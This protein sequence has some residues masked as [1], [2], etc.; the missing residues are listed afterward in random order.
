MPSLTVAVSGSAAWT[1]GAAPSVPGSSRA[2]GSAS[3]AGALPP[4]PPPPAFEASPTTASTAPT[5]TVSSSCTR[6]SS[7]VP[8]AGE[9]I[10]VSTL[11][12]E[13]SSSG[14]SASTWSPTCLS[15]RLT[16]PSLTLSPRAGSVT[17]VPPPPLAPWVLSAVGAGVSS[18][19]VPP[20]S[21]G[22]SGSKVGADDCSGSTS[23]AGSDSAGASGSAGASASAAA[24]PPPASPPPP[25]SASLGSPIT[26][27]TA[28]TSTVS[29]SA[30]LISSSTP[31]VG[32]GISVSTLSVET[33]SSG[34][35]AST[36]SPTCLSHR[37]TV[38][39]VTLSPRAGRVTDVD[40]SR[41]LLHLCGI[42]LDR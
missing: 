13:T 11:S 3:A 24:S 10:S 29:S 36:W 33:S 19:G 35:S 22:A 1:S 25:P 8:D 2:S 20:D 34:S 7:R 30:A 38:P 17:S 5:A 14:S 4:E 12:V 21:S 16:V 42:G 6:I 39:S 40:M 27:S 26:A 23:A 31:E 9:G 32:D 15:Q 28:P 18:T 41:G 37:L